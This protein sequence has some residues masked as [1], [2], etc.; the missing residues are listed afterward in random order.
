MFRWTVFVNT[1]ANV[2]FIYGLYLGLTNFPKLRSHFRI[3]GVGVVTL[4]K[5]RTEDSQILD[6]NVNK[7][8]HGDLAPG[9]GGCLVYMTTVSVTYTIQR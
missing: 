6:A 2:Y 5:L 7:N 8:R 9:M 1:V 4:S 3:W